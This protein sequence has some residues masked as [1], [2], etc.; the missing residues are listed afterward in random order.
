MANLTVSSEQ[1]TVGSGRDV[2]RLLSSLLATGRF[3]EDTFGGSILH[4]Q[5]LSI[6]EIS[7]DHPVHLAGDDR[8]R[9]TLHVDRISPVV[10]SAPGTTCRYT[11]RRT[12]AHVAVAVWDWLYPPVGGA[13]RRELNPSALLGEAAARPMGTNAAGRREPFSTLDEALHH[14]DCLPEPWNSHVEVRVGGAVDEA[15]LR[16]AVNVA[17]SRHPKAQVRIAIPSRW[18]PGYQWEFTSEPDVDPVDVMVCEDDAALAGARSELVGMLVPLL[19][20]PPLRV[21]LARHAA[22]DVVILSLNRSAGDGISALRF[23]RSIARAYSGRPDP[24]P[25]LPPSQLEIR[26]ERGWLPTLTIVLGE[27]GQALKR[28]VHLASDGGEDRA[29][30]GFHHL[31]LTAEQTSALMQACRDED[32]LTNLLLAA[33]H[34]TISGWNADHGMAPGTIRLLVSQNLRPQRWR[35]EVVGNLLF[36]LTVPVNPQQQALPAA[37]L[38]AVRRRTRQIKDDRI[39]FVIVDL[40]NHLWF[41]PLRAKQAIVDL[42]CRGMVIPTAVL[43]HL[44]VVEDDLG[45]GEGLGQPVE[46][47]CSP[48]ARMPMGLGVGAVTYAG[49]LHLTFRFRHALLGADA[50]SLFAERYLSALT[51]Y[52]DQAEWADPSDRS[53]FV[54]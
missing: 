8:G 53:S 7:D 9:L 27:I 41:L 35:N 22:G 11:L 51:L 38:K 24:L 6:R 1:D 23:L 47:T 40:L 15:R 34:L 49:R 32:D 25:D 3:C 37:T 48:P 20:S 16:Q 13:R 44:S 19:T 30:Y 2:R 42:A 28:S 18:R 54:G 45:F 39:A 10:K 50:A 33:L 17:L 4:P 26:G 29:G 43:S 46:V 36:A 21:R 14:L 5:K 52:A 31:A 12:L